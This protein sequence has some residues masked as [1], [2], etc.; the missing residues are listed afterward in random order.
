MK[1]FNDLLY[2]E[3]FLQKFQDKWNKNLSSGYISVKNELYTLKVTDNKRKL[4][5]DRNNKL[6][7][8]V[9]F[10]INKDKEIINK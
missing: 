2:K 10:V 4:I 7:G 5:Y 1:D 6:I 3:S 9:P 8:T